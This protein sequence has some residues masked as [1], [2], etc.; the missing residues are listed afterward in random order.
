LSAAGASTTK[1]RR[2]GRRAERRARTRGQ[3]AGAL[4]DH[5]IRPQQQRLWDRQTQGLGGLETDHLLECLDEMGIGAGPTTGGEKAYAI[6]LRRLLGLGGERRKNETDSEPDQ[7]DGRG[8]SRRIWRVRRAT[9]Y[10]M[11]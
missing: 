6:D 4:L 5:L 7:P 8:P 10:S 11:T 2:R 3:L 1:A 9:C